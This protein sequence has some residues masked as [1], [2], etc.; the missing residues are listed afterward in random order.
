MTTRRLGNGLLIDVEGEWRCAGV[1]K[2]R[3]SRS[4]I[5]FHRMDP[6]D[7]FERLQRTAR[8]N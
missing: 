2:V 3:T 6:N 4:T 7:F 8:T 5:V 1:G